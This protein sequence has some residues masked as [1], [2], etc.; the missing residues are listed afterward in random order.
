[1]FVSLNAVPA[2][3]QSAR[4]GSRPT[5][6]WTRIEAFKYA[7]SKGGSAERTLYLESREASGGEHPV[8]RLRIQTPGQPDFVLTNEF[9]WW[10]KLRDALP[11]WFSKRKNAIASQYV[12]GLETS[13]GGEPHIFLF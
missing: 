1:M 8:T 5:E 12:F 13:I 9:Y 7:P 6:R 10:I 4:S 3:S 2:P 11:N